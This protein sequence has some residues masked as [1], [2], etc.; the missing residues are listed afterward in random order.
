MFGFVRRLGLSDEHAQD[1]VQEAFARLWS[2]MDRGTRVTDP[3]AWAY[4]TVY[5]LAMDEHR[6]RRRVSGLVDRLGG[7]MT[8]SVA[9]A[10]HSDRIAG[11]DRGR[12]PADTTAPGDLPAV[13]RGP[14]VRGHRGR[15]GD[16]RERSP[17]PRNAG[18]AHPPGAAGPGFPGGRPVMDEERI[19]RALR[20]GPADEPRYSPLGGAPRCATGG[21]TG[22]GSGPR[23]SCRG[24]SPLPARSSCRSS[25][26]GR[27]TRLPLRRMPSRRSAHRARF[28]SP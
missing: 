1:C 14:S 20:A 26:C 15:P 22:S 24:R 13:S 11:L 25:S 12:P 5:R 3:K 28:G 9:A 8:H 7:R 2:E 17:E 6:L 10:D 23:S 4:R 21:R 27:A 16:D 19:E 18:D